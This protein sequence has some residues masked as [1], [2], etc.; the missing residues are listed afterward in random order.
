MTTED[1]E[2]CSIYFKLSTGETL[3]ASTT[4]SVLLAMIAE[5]CE[6]VIVDPEKVTV[7]KLPVKE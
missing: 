1:I 6:F 3:A 2:L 4:N 7:G 5:M